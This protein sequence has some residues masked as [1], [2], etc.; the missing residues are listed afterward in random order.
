M[1]HRHRFASLSILY[2]V[3]LT[4]YLKLM[5]IINSADNNTR[6]C[7]SVSLFDKCSWRKLLLINYNFM[8]R[9]FRDCTLILILRLLFKNCC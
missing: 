1:H 3:T 5:V 8:A 7:F 9:V 4:K 2:N 6:I